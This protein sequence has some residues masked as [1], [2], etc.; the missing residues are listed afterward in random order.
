MKYFILSVLLTLTLFCTAQNKEAEVKRA[1]DFYKQKDYKNALRVIEG[2]L[3][4]DSTN[5]DCLFI[6]GNILFESKDYQ[7]SY[8]TF[9][10]LIQFYPFQ[11]IPLSQRGLILR[12]V[13]EF[14]YSIIDFDRALKLKMADTL[15]LSILVNRGAAK[16]SMRDFKGAYT[17]FMMAYEIDSL[18]VAVLNN[19]AAVCDEVGKGDKTLGYLYK[20]IQIDSTLSGTYVNIG[21]KY[22]GMGEHKKAITFFDKAVSLDPGE[23][24]AYSNRSYNRMKTGDFEGAMLDINKSISIYP[25]NSYAFRNRALI[26]MELKKTKEACKDL[27]KALELGFTKMYGDEV[28]VLKTKNCLQNNP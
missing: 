19:L 27:E 3:K 21:F 11:P 9:S 2:V 22:Q 20:I 25:E 14:E 23:P 7:N 17:D 15:R 24:L 18:N 6:M 13:Q 26:Y 12:T 8:T 16:I 28:E 4:I 5:Y 1:T 10:K